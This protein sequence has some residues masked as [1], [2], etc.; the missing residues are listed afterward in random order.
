MISIDPLSSS[1]TSTNPPTV[2]TFVTH[3]SG[4][5]GIVVSTP[6]GPYDHA[7]YVRV[8][9]LGIG[10]ESICDCTVTDA[11]ITELEMSSAADVYWIANHRSSL[12]GAG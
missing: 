3:V 2:G 12:L 5:H 11:R 10:S 8:L 4:G 9:W 6:T 7:V 1:Y